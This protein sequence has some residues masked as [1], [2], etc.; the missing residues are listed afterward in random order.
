MLKSGTMEYDEFLKER[1]VLMARKMKSYF[2]SLG[3]VEADLE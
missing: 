2:Q 3:E 1:R